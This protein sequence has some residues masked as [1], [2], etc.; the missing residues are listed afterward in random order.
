MLRAIH[1]GSWYP[2]GSELN[3][4]LIAALKN[5]SPFSAKGDLRAIIVPHAGYKY[6]VQTSMN[7]F[8]QI[9]PTKFRR[10]V[11]MGPSH[12]IPI[13]CCSIPDAQFAESPYGNIPFDT[14]TIF[15]LL[16]DSPSFFSL[17]PSHIASQEHSLEME[18]PLLK[19]IFK[20]RPFSIIPIMIGQVSS[21]MCAQIASALSSLFEDKSTLFV[22]S[23]DFTHWGRR[24]G[25]TYL[26]H[27]EEKKE[28]YE[29]IEQID[30]MAAEKIQSGDPL[31]FASYLSETRATICGKCA[32]LVMMNIFKNYQLTFPAYSK[33]SNITSKDDSS[34]SYF[35]GVLRNEY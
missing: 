32:I 16:Q 18:F 7:A 34:V 11:V 4:L 10:V 8:A 33:S 3:N 12:S 27:T 25:Y 28:I 21:S 22:V 19:F 24:F 17:L 31:K 13:P 23:S 35:A 30:M 14:T 6:C 5:T 20:D 15:K 29:L 2:S 9:D 1:M 26:P